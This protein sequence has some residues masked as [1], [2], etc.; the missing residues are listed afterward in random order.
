MVGSHPAIKHEWLEFTGV[1]LGA[2]IVALAIARLLFVGT[3]E[4]D[5][6]VLLGVVAFFISLRWAVAIAV[7]IRRRTNG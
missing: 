1:V 3:R 6:T 2:L 7:G 4:W 5:V